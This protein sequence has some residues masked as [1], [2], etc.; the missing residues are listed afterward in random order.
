MSGWG[1]FSQD[2]SLLTALIR[3]ETNDEASASICRQQAWQS[4]AWFTRCSF[5]PYFTFD[6]GIVTSAFLL[7]DASS[8]VTTTQHHRWWLQRVLLAEV[9]EICCG[10]FFILI[11]YSSV[12]TWQRKHITKKQ[13]KNIILCRKDVF[14]SIFVYVEA[15]YEFIYLKTDSRTDQNLHSPAHFFAPLRLYLLREF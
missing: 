7:H 3:T 14:G 4:S 2:G 13:E 10:V 15:Q 9:V 5:R 8:L 11:W 1:Y 6:Q 12:V